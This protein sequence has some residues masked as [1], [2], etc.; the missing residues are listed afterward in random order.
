MEENGR[1]YDNKKYLKAMSKITTYFTKKMLEKEITSIEDIKD[2]WY[3][4][5]SASS[6]LNAKSG[7]ET[8]ET[9]LQK[10]NELGIDINDST[11]ELPSSLVNCIEILQDIKEFDENR[12]TRGKLEKLEEINWTSGED[13]IFEIIYDELD[14]EMN[15]NELQAKIMK[16]LYRGY[17]KDKEVDNQ[18]LADFVRGLARIILEKGYT[19]ENVTLEK[20]SD[21]E[22]YNRIYKL[23][24]G[25]GKDKQEQLV[26][27]YDP[28][29][30]C[31]CQME[32]I[33]N[34][35]NRKQ[36][37]NEN[38]SD[39]GA[40]VFVN[41]TGEYILYDSTENYRLFFEENEL[42]G[43]NN[44]VFPSVI[45][46]IMENLKEAQE[47]KSK[48]EEMKAPSIIIKN[49]ENIIEKLTKK[50]NG[51]AAESKFV[52]ADIEKLTVEQGITLTDIESEMN[53]L[54][55]VSNEK[56]DEEISHGSSEK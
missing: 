10:I 37:F 13:T 36:Y 33:T 20:I 47:R 7:V 15:P 46:R 30:Y 28:D 29:E 12:T 44:T 5:E 56:E 11:N 55:G 24:I 9:L 45:E 21:E 32:E 25:S 2:V 6:Q 19:F 41:S 51:I 1:Y 16:A 17:M 48:L 42:E 4:I 31:F 40:R 14:V 3:M 18:L 27:N 49:E 38:I 8:V 39:N 22:G 50:L 53:S 34:E 35:Q 26:L 43:I 23:Y 52:P 54:I